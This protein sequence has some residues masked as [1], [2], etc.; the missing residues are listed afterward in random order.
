MPMHKVSATLTL[1]ISSN[2]SFIKEISIDRN[3]KE[4]QSL[5]K[6]FNTH[7]SLYNKIWQQG[8][9]RG[10]HSENE[11]WSKCPL[12]MPRRLQ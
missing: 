10:A 2:G 8:E 1:T 9:E 4:G 6:Q 12:W 3:R 5:K 7:I 11:D